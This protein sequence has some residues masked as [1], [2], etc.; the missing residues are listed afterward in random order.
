MHN[1]IAATISTP[2]G[3]VAACWE[4]TALR[5]VTIGNATP[6]G[7]HQALGLD[8]DMC[9]IAALT[10]EQR[11]LLHRLAAAAVGA[12]DDF[13]DI[14]LDLTHL[15][16]FARRVVERCRKIAP[17]KTMSYGQLAA[18]CGSPRAARAVGNTMRMNRFPL[19]VPCHRVVG[20]HG[21]LGG[22]SAPDGVALKRRMLAGERIA[23]S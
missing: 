23:V 21:S 17:G 22:F 13:R 19:I 9:D 4:G 20:S 2:Q 12:D 18:A 6:A 15:G 1:L 14:K 8:A 7:A 11:Q 5:R 10:A 3:W 16:P